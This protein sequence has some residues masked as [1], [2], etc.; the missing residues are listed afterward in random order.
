MERVGSTG[1]SIILAV[2]AS[3]EVQHSTRQGRRLNNNLNEFARVSSSGVA[4]TEKRGAV[5]VG[6]PVVSVEG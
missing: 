2:I 1:S 4:K 3:R 5:S 6:R